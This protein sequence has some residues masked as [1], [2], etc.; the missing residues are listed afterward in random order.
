MKLVDGSRF[1]GI[2]EMPAASLDRLGTESAFEV[3]ARAK[4]LEA[5]GRHVIHLELGEPELDL[6][7]HIVVAGAKSLSDGHTHYCPAPGLPVCAGLAGVKVVPPAGRSTVTPAP[8]R[9]PRQPPGA[10]PRSLSTD[11]GFSRGPT[12]DKEHRW[13]R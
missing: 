3:L 2:A 4:Q 5:Q 6:L 1:R 13:L 11:Y 10:E 7:A 9:R 12:T 8:R